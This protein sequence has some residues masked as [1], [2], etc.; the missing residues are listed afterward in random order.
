MSGKRKEPSDEGFTFVL[1]IPGRENETPGASSSSVGP[2]PVDSAPSS[3]KRRRSNPDTAPLG[4]SKTTRI[5]ERLKKHQKTE[6]V[7]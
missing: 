6:Q 7:M 5:V 3:A 4:S 2:H 1:E